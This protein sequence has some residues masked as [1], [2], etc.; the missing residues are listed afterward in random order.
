[1]GN[2]VIPLF[3]IH[4]RL[5]CNFS[6]CDVTKRTDEAKF[7][8]AVDHCGLLCQKGLTETVSLTGAPSPRA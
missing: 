5:Q 1:M 4:V 7:E 3:Q 6:P 2:M 8:Q